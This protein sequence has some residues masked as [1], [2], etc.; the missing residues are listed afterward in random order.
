[1][2]WKNKAFKELHLGRNSQLHKQRREWVLL[3]KTSWGRDG[4]EYDKL[5]AVNPLLQK[6]YS[7]W[8][9]ASTVCSMRSVVVFLCFQVVIRPQMKYLSMLGHLTE[10]K[11]S[12][13]DSGGQKVLKKLHQKSGSI[14]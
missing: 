6:R 11:S 10:M 12:E 7:L 14:L 1:M 13:V 9:D 2:V 3:H 8:W 5:S 4:V